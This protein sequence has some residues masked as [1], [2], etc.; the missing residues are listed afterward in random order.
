MRV[1]LY[2]R[3]STHDQQ[4]LGLQVESMSANFQDRGWI[5]AKRVEDIG[6]GSKGGRAARRC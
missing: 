6:S 5:T 2:D 3:V 1:A 4:T